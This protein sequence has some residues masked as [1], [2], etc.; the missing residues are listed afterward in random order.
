MIRGSITLTTKTLASRA[1]AMAVVQLANHYESRIMIEHAH[2]IVNAKST[3]GLL[4]LCADAGTQ[5][6]L[7]VEGPDEKEANTA[8]RDMIASLSE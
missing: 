7:V 3:L 4:S 6:T 2:K 1:N 5:M 8:V